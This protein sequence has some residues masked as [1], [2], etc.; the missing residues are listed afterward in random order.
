MKRVS[1]ML[2]KMVNEKIKPSIKKYFNSNIYIKLSIFIFGLYHFKKGQIY[3]G[4][5]YLTL[6]ISLILYFI[7]EGIKNLTGLMTLGTK[8][9]DMHI[10]PNGIPIV[11]EGDNSMK[12]LLYGVVAIFMLVG[13]VI[14]MKSNLKS[15]Y[16]LE[17]ST[18]KGLKPITLKEEIKLLFDDNIARLF[19]PLPLIGIILFTV[20][21]LVYMIL[22]AFTN[23]DQFHQPP[24]NLFTWIGLGNFSEIFSSL[25]SL[26][27]TFWSIFGWTFIW[28]IFSTFTCYFGGM[29]LALLINS[30]GI[31]GKGFW[32]TIFVITIAVPGFIS[33]LVMRTLLGSQGVINNLLKEFGFI[34]TSLP[35]LTDVT[36]ARGTVIVVNMWIGIPYSMLI[37]SGILLN[38]SRELYESAKLDGANKYQIFRHITLPYMLFVTTPY[39]ITNFIANIN[40]FNAIYFLTKGGPSTLEYYKAGKTDL[41]VTWLY[42]LA[43]DSFD[44]NYASAIGIII[45]IISA[46][47]SLLIYRRSS[48]NKE[49]GNF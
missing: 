31:K 11:I 29:L 35:F 36:W 17:E 34:T 25:S 3:K 2:K 14:L 49:Q 5:M 7:F 19:L 10:D 9:Q 41:L 22:I 8:Q 13:F 26:G 20:V 39:L 23:Y 6:E 44:Y 47:I 24:G 33:L 1:L 18:N 48:A 30:K 15:A 37:T 21:P 43:T 38:I 12:M 42:K 4:L 28:A 27:K 32:R 46:T 45:F 40:N 16:A